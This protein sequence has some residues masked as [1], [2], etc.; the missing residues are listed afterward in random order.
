MVDL[1]DSITLVKVSDVVRDILNALG[2]ACPLIKDGFLDRFE[3]A[4]RLFA[5]AA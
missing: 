4:A 2:R 1:D 5:Q 3:K